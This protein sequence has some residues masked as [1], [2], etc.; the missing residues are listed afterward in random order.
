VS[1]H[2]GKLKAVHDIYVFATLSFTQLANKC[3][4]LFVVL[5][6]VENESV[7]WIGIL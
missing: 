3:Q 6:N 5:T 7:F 4:E 2:D 1:L